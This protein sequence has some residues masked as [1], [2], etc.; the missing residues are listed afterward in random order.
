[1][2]RA[3]VVALALCPALALPQAA[4]ARPADA[5]DAC[6]RVP[7]SFG[8]MFSG[9]PAGQWPVGQLNALADEVMADEEA[10][11]TPEGEIDAEENLDIDAGYTYA[12][13]LI[14]HDLTLDNRPNDLTTPVNPRTL[15]N[16]RTPAF[17][18][19]SVYGSGPAASP[20]LYAA[21]GARLLLGAPLTGTP[22]DPG[23]VDMPRS[24]NGLAL[25]G[26]A[27]DDENRIV[28][29]LHTILLRFHNG[30]VDRLARE[31]PRW[32]A[33]RLFAEAQRQVRWHYQWAVLTD[34]LPAVV[35]RPTLTAVLGQSMRRPRLSFY[36]PCAQG[37]PI[38]FSMAAYRFGHSMVRPI[39]RLN[40]AMP[41]RLPVFASASAGAIDIGGFRPSP[42]GFSVNWRLFFEMTPPRTAA[43][44]QTSYRIDN[45]VVFPLSL[46]PLGAAGTGPTSLAHR[47]LLRGQQVG[48]PTG[49]A[50]A[51]AMGVRPLRAD[52]ILVGKATDD[53]AD[54]VPIATIA[55]ALAKR[56]PLWT[57]VLAE[58]TATAFPVR[59]GKIAGPQV[60]PFRLGPV[61]GRIVTETLAGLLLADRGSVLHA[62]RFRPDRAVASGGRFG[63]EELIAATTSNALARGGGGLAPSPAADRPTRSP[64]GDGRRDD[65][66]ERRS[67]PRDDPPRDESP[68]P[69]EPRPTDEGNARSR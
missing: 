54:A 48:L 33:A 65:R 5:P 6:P 35:G 39:Y 12:G 9:L 18:L 20:H 57:Y 67:R 51:R 26:D 4:S 50:V 61:G 64:R 41:D 24:A 66:T 53:E 44:P 55:P 68:P 30:W 69:E 2:R 21:D 16:S 28:A 46:L 29:G 43:I 19:D 27:R 37:M 7:Q 62:R 10:D 58:A 13:Q 8:R 42:P 23:S 60:A 1:M 36:R 25:S 11:V 40:G 15:V 38:E 3:L 17:D 59:G 31:H 34:F 14:D 56:T 32:P 52:Q 49:Q 47:N 45:S 63:F 22:T